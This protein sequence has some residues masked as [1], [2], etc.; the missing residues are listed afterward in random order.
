MGLNKETLALIEK[1]TQD[2]SGMH[3]AISIKRA[4]VLYLAS[5][6]G[7][8]TSVNA[9]DCARMISRFAS[10][11]YEFRT[12]LLAFATL[13]AIN[14]CN[15]EAVSSLLNAMLSSNARLAGPAA[16]L[17]N[18]FAIQAEHK[19]MIKKVFHNGAFDAAQKEQIKK[20]A[21]FLN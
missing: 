9:G 12:R 3:N 20:Q 21:S 1:H 15:E 14:F 7:H 17:V 16:E 11:R 10:Y 18:H 13:K 5:K 6:T 4:E 19:L 8:T 2:V